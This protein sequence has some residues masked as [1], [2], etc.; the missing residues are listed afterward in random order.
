MARI[1]VLDHRIWRGMEMPSGHVLVHGNPLDTTN[2]VIRSL[3]NS[4][5]LAPL[6]KS[7]AVELAF[8]PDPDDQIEAPASITRDTDQI[9]GVTMPDTPLEADPVTNPPVD[10]ADVE[11]A[12]PASSGLS[13]GSPLFKTLPPTLVDVKTPTG[14]VDKPQSTETSAR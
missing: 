8:D 11:G 1:T 2:D 3:D 10:K 13:S 14:P 4:R 7:G 6:V 9:P 12:S 5:F